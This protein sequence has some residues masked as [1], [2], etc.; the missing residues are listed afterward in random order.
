MAPFLQNLFWWT[1]VLIATATPLTAPSPARADQPL[2]RQPAP[3][4]KS[5]PIPL[6]ISPQTTRITGPLR[7]DGFID[8]VAALDQ[9]F[10]QGVTPENNA[11]VLLW[12]TMGPGGLTKSRWNKE[13][14]Q[15]LSISPLSQRKD[16]YFQ[17][18]GISLL[19]EKGDYFLTLDQYFR[20][21]LPVSR[22]FLDRDDTEKLKQF[23]NEL[24]QAVKRP[25]SA[26]EFP[27]LADWL[28]TNEKPLALV[29][30]ASRR[31]RRYDPLLGPLVIAVEVPSS[32]FYR[33][34]ARALSVRAM[35]RL[36]QGQVEKA[37]DDLLAC[38]RLAR[39]AGQGMELMDALY[40]MAIEGI[41]CASDQALVQSG[42]LTAAQA[43]RVKGDLDKL[44]RLPRIEDKIDGGQRFMI[45][46]NVQWF[47]QG[48][49]SFL[50]LL[51]E[52]GQ[53]KGPVETALQSA[54]DWVIQNFVDWDLALRIGNSWCDRVI[55][56]LHRPTR[57]QRKEALDRVRRD[58]YRAKAKAV[59]PEYLEL[60]DICDPQEA[61]SQRVGEIIV[62]SFLPVIFKVSESEDRADMILDL[63]RLA[64]AL[65]AFRAEH[66]SY[67]A[68]LAVLVPQY[69]N[70]VP[71]DLFSGRDLHYHREGPGF[72][73]YSVGV[74]GKDDGG[75]SV[76]DRT[77]W[78][79]HWDD[80]VV[81][82]PAKKP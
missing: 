77:S 51:R 67:P 9:R 55:E 8:Y 54:G 23:K 4:V 18:L 32:A 27:L 47:A 29:V 6:T 46:D 39:L 44:P 16:E 30:E 68:N 12:K 71:Q 80:L 28:K 42:C 3:T 1:L 14:F 22:E 38:H 60:S 75:K 53:T 37:W 26:R 76:E 57:M 19:P 11:S 36:K 79:E 48:K 5:L 73:L 52:G 65:A 72:L 62:S 78:E 81:R 13:Y 49:L 15:K 20:K 56:A 66:G 40:G 64:L 43:R 34:G 69:I 58:S 17:K 2:D 10:H 59:F 24:D 41:A 33:E 21:T 70:R 61:V 50:N 31:A 74:N 35:L 45:L 7:K 63:D 82:V 25:W